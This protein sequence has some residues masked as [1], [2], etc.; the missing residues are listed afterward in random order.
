[1]AWAVLLFGL[2]A[3]PAAGSQTSPEL[4][5]VPK[6]DLRPNVGP[7]EVPPVWTWRGIGGFLLLGINVALVAVTVWLWWTRP[8]RQAQPSPTAWA[9]AE[10]ARLRKEAETVCDPASVER[11]CTSLS[12]LVRRYVEQR[13][14]IPALEQTTP[15]FLGSLADR[16]VLPPSAKDFLTSFLSRADLVKFAHAA[17]SQEELKGWIKQAEVFVRSSSTVESGGKEHSSRVTT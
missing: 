12:F 7:E 3:L 4:P 17:M 6:L 9:L 11:L 8:R 16:N 1:M 15:E 13:L 2:T 10:L 5:A 14:E